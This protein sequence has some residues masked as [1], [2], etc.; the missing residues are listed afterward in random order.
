M[1]KKK[2]VVRKRTTKKVVTVDT[3]TDVTTAAR[4]KL[5][6]TTHFPWPLRPYQEKVYAAFRKGIR[7]FMLPWHRRAGKDIFGLSLSSNEMRS[8]VGTYVHCFPKTAHAERAIWD[9]VDPRIGSKF[10]DI[11]FGDIEANRDNRKLLIEAYNGSV[12]QMIGSDNYN[13]MVGSN[14]VGAVFSEWALCDPRAWDYIRPMLLENKGWAVFISTY[15]GR[16]NHMWKMAQELKD[17]PEWYFEELDVT[18]TTDI[19]GNRILT[20]ADIQSER[21]SGMSEAM[22]QQEY[23]CNPAAVFDGAIYGSETTALREALNRQKAVYDPAR[24]VYCVWNL[25]LPVH[26]SYLL[27]QPGERPN[28]LRAEMDD[29]T[30]MSDAVARAER[31]PIP[32]Q[33]HLIHG[34][35]R[36]Y[37]PGFSGLG[38]NPHLLINTNVTLEYLQAS[39]MLSRCNIDMEKSEILLDGLGGYVRRERFDSQVSEVMYS[40]D[41]V[42]SWHHR[43]P[44]CLETF[45]AWDYNGGSGGWS[46]AIDYTQADRAARTIL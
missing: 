3:R 22:I 11:A 37:A 12:W 13:R 15:R 29:W 10:V 23:Y 20:D 32:I 19:Y 24:P 34:L 28:I 14:I 33:G 38:L 36:D 6:G 5:K 27:I 45:A 42:H 39:S 43:L 16:G 40:D 18:K 41:V 2:R 46:K 1:P 44:A 31:N 21:D 4:E 30:T 8:R 35:Q 17:N 9:G 26:A 25:D 7:R